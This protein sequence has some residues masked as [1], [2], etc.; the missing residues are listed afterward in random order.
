MS[1]TKQKQGKKCFPFP[2]LLN[3]KGIINI[4]LQRR[5]NMLLHVCGSETRPEAG[6]VVVIVWPKALQMNCI[7]GD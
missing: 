7:E 5:E 3:I 1:E 2:F 6:G 4:F